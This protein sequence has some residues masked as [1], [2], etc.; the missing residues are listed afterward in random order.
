MAGRSRTQS[1]S[2]LPSRSTRT[3]SKNPVW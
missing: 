2:T 1:T 3:S